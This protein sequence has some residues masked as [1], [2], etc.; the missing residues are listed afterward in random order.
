LC[1]NFTVTA[2]QSPTTTYT[3]TV[4]DK[5]N[6]SRT[7]TASVNVTPTA[8]TITPPSNPGCNGVLSYSASVSGQT[9]CSFVWTIDGQS[10]AT[11]VAGGGADAAR[12]A[13]VSGTGNSVLEYRALDNVCH[14]IACTAT[15]SISGAGSC[16][17]SGSVRAKQCVS[18]TLGCT[19]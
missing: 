17:A 5:N 12:I 9:G 4:R 7:A 19:N 15:C 11:F 13:R 14:T 10:L 2:T 16:S 18:A 6:C 8:L 1:L 3:L